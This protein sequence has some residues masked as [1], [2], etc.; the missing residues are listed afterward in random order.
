MKARFNY[1]QKKKSYL[2]IFRHID[3]PQYI[4]KISQLVYILSE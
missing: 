2:K 4:C 1:K 3:N